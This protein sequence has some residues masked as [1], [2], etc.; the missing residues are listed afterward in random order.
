[1]NPSDIREA[2][3]TPSG[4][5]IRIADKVE[6]LESVTFAQLSESPVLS[7]TPASTTVSVLNISALNFANTSPVTVTNLL[8]GQEGQV[9]K[10][11][12]DGN[13]TLDHGA[14]ILTNTGADKLLAANKVYT[15]TLFGTTWVEDE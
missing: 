3:S 13:T 6:F 14:N 1:M 11:L 15:F 7:V 5:I 4:S 2:L 9:I 8:N 12:G 10:I